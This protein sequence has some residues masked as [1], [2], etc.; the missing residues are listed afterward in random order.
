VRNE[1]QSGG[2]VLYRDVKSIFLRVQQF[3]SNDVHV[4]VYSVVID[5]NNCNLCRLH[6]IRLLAGTTM[7]V[8]LS[9]RS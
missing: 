7:S 9:V 8:C 2:H 1:W 3:L 6:R 4:T 5:A